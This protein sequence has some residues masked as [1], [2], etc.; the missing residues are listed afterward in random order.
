ML[1]AGER[2]RAVEDCLGR[3]T[4]EYRLV[5]V[6]HHRDG[7]PIDEI[8]RRLNR[9]AD[10]ARRLWSRAIDRLHELMGPP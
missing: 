4:E 8:G 10:A 3:L 2:R 1:V 7:L 9:S 5:V 6:W